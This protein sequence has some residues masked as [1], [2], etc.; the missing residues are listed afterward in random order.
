MATAYLVIA[1]YQVVAGLTKTAI[2]VVTIHT[3]ITEATETF[4]ASDSSLA[5]YWVALLF[6]FELVVFVNDLLE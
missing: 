1:T 6:I 3:S 4:A 5:R 2:A